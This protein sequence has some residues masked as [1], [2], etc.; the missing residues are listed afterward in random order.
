[1]LNDQKL[2]EI[3]ARLE[4]LQENLWYDL[5]GV[6]FLNSFEMK[7]KRVGVKLELSCFRG[8]LCH[9]ID[10][11]VNTSAPCAFVIRT[12]SLF[13]LQGQ[14]KRR[15]QFILEEI[16]LQY[17]YPRLDINVTKGLNH[18]LKSPFCVHPK[19]GKVCL[20]FHPRAAEKF[21]PCTVPTIR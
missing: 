18:L 17:A 11:L 21:N 8:S 12:V 14:L 2:N 10:R 9:V 1:M 6:S 13:P 16:M 4:I 5:Q 15:H 20:P 19:T 3:S 7:L